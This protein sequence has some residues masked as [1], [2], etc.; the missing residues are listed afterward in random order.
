M[1]TT[2]SPWRPFRRPQGLRG[3]IVASVFLA[4]AATSLLS[5]W[6]AS[7][8]YVE[9][10]GR[11]R[12]TAA[13]QGWD[14]LEQARAS[15]GRAA[16]VL[17]NLRTDA[18]LAGGRPSHELDYL[19]RKEP[20][21]LGIGLLHHTGQLGPHAGLS[22]APGDLTRPVTRGIDLRPGPTHWTALLLRADP[23]SESSSPAIYAIFDLGEPS[24]RDPMRLVALLDPRGMIVAASGDP[25]AHAEEFRVAAESGLSRLDSKERGDRA[26]VVSATQEPPGFLVSAGEPI[27]AA[28]R[29]AAQR[30]I[31][32]AAVP[33]LAWLLLLVSLRRWLDRALVR[34]T[35]DLGQA[36][37]EL[38]HHP[39][40]AHKLPVRLAPELEPMAEGL[41]ELARRLAERE[42]EHARDAA[43]LKE[44]ED[45]YRLLV[46]LSPDA[47]FVHA[48]GRLVYIN[49]AGAALL[50]AE[51]RTALL[52]RPILDLF[53]AESRPSV[54]RRLRELAESGG[55][56]PFREE[57]LL[58][59]DG[60]AI[61]V[62]LGASAVSVGGKLAVQVIAHE[63]AT[64]KTLE[65]QLRQAQK[66]EAVGQ[67]AGGIAHDFNNILTVI[68]GYAQTS[69]RLAP[70][71]GKLRE[72]LEQIHRAG[73]R[74][75]GLTSK[76][77]AFS[78]RQVHHPR[79]AELSALMS[80][81]QKLLRRLIRENIEIRLDLAEGLPAVRV[82]PLQIEQVV[83]NLAVNA[84]D[85]MPDGGLVTIRT[86]AQE[87]SAHE[88]DLMPGLGRARH[89]V[90]SVSDTGCGMDDA[91]RARIF[92]PFFTTKDK[93]RG[94]GLGLAIVYGIVRQSGGQ[95]SVTSAPGTGS[96]FEIHLPAA[97]EEAPVA[98]PPPTAVP[99]RR[100]GSEVV[101]VVED[102]A[103][104]RRLAV[105]TLRRAGYESLEAGDADEAKTI[106]AA[107]A[108][109]IDL[110]LT[111]VVM[112]GGGGPEV[113][114]AI[115]ERNPSLRVLYMSGYADDESLMQRASEDGVAFLPKPF[116]LEELVA[117]VDSC[118]SGR[119]AHA[120]AA[121]LQ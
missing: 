72:D 77:L 76:L 89:V 117:A 44:S 70:E 38:A 115:S 84:Q 116:T 42:S 39:A 22:P 71:S 7:A 85:A 66:L 113:A 56:S 50:G 91:T 99:S 20:A 79:V 74:A 100:R 1:S 59:V 36:A 15:L 97:A 98:P 35:A 68:L 118:L 107:L 60:T 12:E 62:E 33:A 61:E 48:T 32:F 43:A 3:R 88:S 4:A 10:A 16:R 25:A 64:R 75:A 111:D 110:L 95:I 27:G 58:R 26:L 69:L 24:E 5:G 41:R 8:S 19:L 101:L 78:R 53:H 17:A 87:F 103:E 83:M 23:F 55:S 108:G 121:S 73:T 114:A 92:E 57:R 94:T 13:R 102:D 82:D 34:P 65:S 52:G 30:S 63:I 86:F 18:I 51:P 96:T 2:A 80:E 106:A 109:E 67:L 54:E 90:L 31:A 21:L 93:G 49:P 28:L 112:P 9:A 81:L 37:A 120:T 119:E 105:T 104:V 29:R 14:A 6:A 47:I 45:R 11:I 46:E 40:A